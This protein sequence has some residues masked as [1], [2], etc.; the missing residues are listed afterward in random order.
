MRETQS[1]LPPLTETSTP[2]ALDQD[3]YERASA[4]KDPEAPSRTHD[5]AHAGLVYLQISG[6]EE[7][8]LGARINVD[9]VRLEELR[10]EIRRL[11]ER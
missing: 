9:D 11:L 7:D 2:S 1:S 5:Q 8:L 10:R 6:Q 3:P 4:E